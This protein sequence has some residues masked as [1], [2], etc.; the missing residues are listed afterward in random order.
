MRQGMRQLRQQL[1]EVQRGETQRV[2]DHITQVEIRGRRDV[3][4]ANERVAMLESAAF[5]ASNFG[6]PERSR[7]CTTRS[8]TH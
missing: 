5:A 4:V 3:L 8:D 2:L 6:G 1:T 7:R